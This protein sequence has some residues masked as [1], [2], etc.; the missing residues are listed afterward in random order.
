MIVKFITNPVGRIHIG[1]PE[2]EEFIA[3]SLLATLSIYAR[4]K[5]L[6]NGLLFSVDR[7]GGE[8]ATKLP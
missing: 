3:R 4:L 5:V 6:F 7:T 1:N 8:V 2:K